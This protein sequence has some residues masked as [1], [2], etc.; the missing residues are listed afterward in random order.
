[1]KL[2]I[3]TSYPCQVKLDGRFQ[4]INQ[5]E[6]IEVEY[7]GQD[8]IIR[9]QKNSGM[10][11]VIDLENE[12][13]LY[14]IVKKD[15]KILV[16]LLDGFL[17]ENILCHSFEYNST[18]SSIEVGTKQIVFCGN[19][20]KKVIHLTSPIEDVKV[21]AF[22]FID[23]ISF[24]DKAQRHLIAYN[25]KKNTAKT[26]SAEEIEIGEEGFSLI[27]RDFSY[28]KVKLEYFVDKDGLKLKSK[29][30]DVL[31]LSSPNETV[32][33][34]FMSSIKL[35][36]YQTALTFL[37]KTLSQKLS[38]AALKEYFGEV[39]YFYMLDFSSC[40]AISN[41]SN[42]IYDFTLSE[43]KITDIQTQT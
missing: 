17:A 35:G 20:G 27:K 43:N 15:D 21:G 1:M 23:Y 34:K 30:F 2:N 24:S 39:S 37:S 33:F 31:A 29:D 14:R 38:Q 26:F 36:D 9:P 4:A 22:L 25:P 5:N 7:S 42:V 3:Y 13:P 11:F 12:N 32:P 16:F 8:I 18:K 40:F 28:E 19:V 41:G 6:H 10:P